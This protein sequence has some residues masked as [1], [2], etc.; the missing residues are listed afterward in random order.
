MIIFTSGDP[1]LR[2]PVIRRSNK[3]VAGSRSTGNRKLETGFNDH[4]DF[5]GTPWVLPVL[6]P[7]ETGN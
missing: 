5:L 3:A 2:D 4:L 7:L 1:A 6:D